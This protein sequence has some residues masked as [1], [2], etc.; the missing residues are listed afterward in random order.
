[1]AKKLKSYRKIASNSSLGIFSLIYYAI[2]C[3][4]QIKIKFIVFAYHEI[5]SNYTF[6]NSILEI[7]KYSAAMQ[8]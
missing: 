4:L 1:M 8:I 3:S 7:I 5:C 6:L 2:L